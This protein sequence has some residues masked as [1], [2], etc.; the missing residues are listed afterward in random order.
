ME[1]SK[2]KR[3]IVKLKEKKVAFSYLKLEFHEIRLVPSNEKF[4]KKIYDTLSD[5]AEMNPDE[6]I[7]DE[8]GEMF[9]DENEI[10]KNSMKKDETESNE[11]KKIKNSN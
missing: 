10:L 2:P 4:V 9:Y 11:T 7:E 1:L 3:Y 5:A 6:N 8:E